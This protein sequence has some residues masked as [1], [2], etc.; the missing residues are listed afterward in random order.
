MTSQNPEEA[1]LITALPDSTGGGWGGG[2][3]GRRGA[4]TRGGDR[5]GKEGEDE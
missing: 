3:R 4:R 2:V 1:G 5:G